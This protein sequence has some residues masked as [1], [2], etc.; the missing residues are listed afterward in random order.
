M[1]G[2]HAFPDKEAAFHETKR[3]LKKGGSSIGCFY[4]SGETKRTDFF[5]RHLYVPKVILRRRL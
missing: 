2:F 1:N 3:V 4:I 5:I